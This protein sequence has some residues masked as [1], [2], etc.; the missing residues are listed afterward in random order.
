MRASRFRSSD[1]LNLLLLQLPVRCL[2]CN[3]RDHLQ[4]SV[5]LEIRRAGKIRQRE[6]ARRR[7]AHKDQG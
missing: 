2:S 7:E 1:L 6:H 5:A 3:Q 4:M